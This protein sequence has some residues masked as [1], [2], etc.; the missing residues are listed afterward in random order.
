MTLSFSSLWIRLSECYEI[1]SLYK[2]YLLSVCQ[3][4]FHFQVP[5]S[6][7]PLFTFLLLLSQC[8]LTKEAPCSE[9]TIFLLQTKHSF[10]NKT[11]PRAIKSRCWLYWI[12]YRNFFLVLL[13]IAW[14]H[15]VLYTLVF[16]DQETFFT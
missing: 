13:P 1:L 2:F 14:F 9:H 6:L 11:S 3:F 16:K 5:W 10:H 8:Y 15:L 12:S 4:N 7:Q